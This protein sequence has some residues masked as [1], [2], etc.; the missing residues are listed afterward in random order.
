ML[1][2]SCF[3]NAQFC[4]SIWE[5]RNLHFLVS[6]ADTLSDQWQHLSLKSTDLSYSQQLKGAFHATWVEFPLKML[7]C[8]FCPQGQSQGRYCPCSEVS[9]CLAITSCLLKMDIH[10]PCRPREWRCQSKVQWLAQAHRAGL[11]LSDKQASMTIQKAQKCFSKNSKRPETKNGIF[12]ISQDYCISQTSKV[13]NPQKVKAVHK[14][15]PSAGWELLTPTKEN[16]HPQHHYLQI[17]AW[18]DWEVCRELPCC[19]A[20]LG[21]VTAV[22]HAWSHS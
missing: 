7:W 1:W 5:L 18:G 17:P 16:L 14:A 10:T 13:R 3:S 2:A 19:S 12:G 8:K 22:A 11:S 4:L 21:D 15:S 9:Q 20:C 6:Y